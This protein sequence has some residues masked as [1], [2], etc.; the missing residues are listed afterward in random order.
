MPLRLKI[1]KDTIDPYSIMGPVLIFD[2][3]FLESLTLDESVWLDNFFSTN[4]APVFYVETLAD[5]E[6]EGKKGKIARTPEELVGELANKTP[7]LSSVPNVFHFRLLVEDLMGWEVEVAE[8][9]PIVTGGQYKVAPDGK[10]S[11]DFK[12]FPETAALERW[13]RHDFWE[14]EKEIAQK[15]RRELS[16][17]NF[18]PLITQAKSIVPLNTHFANLE[19]IKKF[20]DGFVKGK[21]NQLIHLVFNILNIPEKPRKLILKRWYDTRPMPFDE[22]APYRAHI[23]KVDLFFLLCLDKGLISKNRPS[24]KIDISYLYYLPF[25]STFASSDKL[26]ARTVPLFMDSEQSLYPD[27]S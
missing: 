2:K 9:R 24:N 20:V 12:Q 16:D 22:F 11:V 27:V 10:V 15:W 1:K 26:H 7:V 19:E 13:I 3:S 8:K 14:I 4:I 25:C 6:K 18:D 23:L 21:Y 5:L 17:V